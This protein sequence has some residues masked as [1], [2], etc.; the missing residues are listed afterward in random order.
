M[1]QGWCIEDSVAAMQEVFFIEVEYLPPAVRPVVVETDSKLQTLESRLTDCLKT[2]L[3]HSTTYLDLILR[4][5]EPKVI[6]A[7]MR[8]KAE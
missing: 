8:I 4:A 2:D 1:L 7:N 3:T 5:T 6:T